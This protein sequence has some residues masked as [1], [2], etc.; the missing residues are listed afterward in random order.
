MEKIKLTE[1]QEIEFTGG[2]GTE[3]SNEETDGSSEE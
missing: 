3:A 1:E 2:K